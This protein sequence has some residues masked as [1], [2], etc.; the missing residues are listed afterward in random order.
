MRRSRISFIT[1]GLKHLLTTGN[2]VL[3]LLIKN[4]LN[5]RCR[6][7][8]GTRCR[9]G[10]CELARMDKCWNGPYHLNLLQHMYVLMYLCC[11][12]LFNLLLHQVH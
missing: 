10:C 9:W 3:Q 1:L 5:V 11:L 4:R 12:Q 2:S 6:L 8:L 7:K